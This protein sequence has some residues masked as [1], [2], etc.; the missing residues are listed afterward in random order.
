MK[1]FWL[2]DSLLDPGQREPWLREGHL[3]LCRLRL[4]P[5]ISVVFVI[6]ATYCID[7]I[8]LFRLDKRVGEYQAV[9]NRLRRKVAWA[10][11]TRLRA[12]A[13]WLSTCVE[14][15]ALLI[16]VNIQLLQI[17]LVLLSIEVCSFVYVPPC[18]K[19][20]IARIFVVTNLIAEILDRIFNSTWSCTDGSKSPLMTYID[21]T[22]L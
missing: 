11:H 8:L 20:A 6:V 10:W 16:W 7:E 22:F 1:H 12:A 2:S 9:N 17:D 5:N 18:I 13:S 14:V 15:V 21:H 19:E 3:P 4:K